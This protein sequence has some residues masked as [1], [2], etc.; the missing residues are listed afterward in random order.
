[1]MR[2]SYDEVLVDASVE[3]VAITV[4]KSLQYKDFGPPPS[5]PSSL[6]EL[7]VLRPSQEKKDRQIFHDY[8]EYIG[9]A[10]LLE[11]DVL[12]SF[13]Q[14]LQTHLEEV[15]C[16]VGEIE[17]WLTEVDL[18][19]DFLND[20]F[21]KEFHFGSVGDEWGEIFD[22]GNA[23][24]FNCFYPVSA[25]EGTYQRYFCSS[26][27]CS[28]LPKYC[29]SRRPKFYIPPAPDIL[30]KASMSPG[31]MGLTF[32]LCTEDGRSKLK[33]FRTFMEM[34]KT[35]EKDEVEEEVCDADSHN[36]TTGMISI[37]SDI[38]SDIDDE[39]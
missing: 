35:D 38:D 6:A 28:N 8:L 34:F 4:K 26:V 11:D 21:D 16:Y 13:L 18:I 17:K 5:I 36:D 33:V 15:Q 25:H 31:I 32:D 22:E 9:R 27:H 24:C 19:V 2:F 10:A 20:L 12:A 23:M 7:V 39:W 3:K 14:K 29:Q 1:M 30:F 37:Y